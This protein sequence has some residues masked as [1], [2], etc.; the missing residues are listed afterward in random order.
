MQRPQ[1]PAGIYGDGDGEA[2]AGFTGRSGSRSRQRG[3]ENTRMRV[4]GGMLALG[5]DYLGTTRHDQTWAAGCQV[6]SHCNTNLLQV[7]RRLTRISLWGLR[8]DELVKRGFPPGEWM[9]MHQDPTHGKNYSPSLANNITKSYSSCSCCSDAIPLRHGWHNSIVATLEVFANKN[10]I[11][12]PASQAFR[13]PGRTDGLLLP[14][15]VLRHSPLRTRR[16][17]PSPHPPP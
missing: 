14:F 5:T 2:H 13:L 11:T 16:S 12:C 3:E 7:R 6:E 8:W 1:Q 17:D 10:L 9:K 15:R 4:R